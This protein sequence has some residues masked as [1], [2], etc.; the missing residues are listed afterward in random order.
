M[1]LFLEVAVQ[2]G[3]DGEHFGKINSI[4]LYFES[5]SAVEWLFLG[6][7]LRYQCNSRG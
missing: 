1:C 3:R 6:L 7:F 4:V 5:L 2:Y